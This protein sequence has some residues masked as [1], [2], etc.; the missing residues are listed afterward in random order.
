LKDKLIKKI[1][2]FLSRNYQKYRIYLYKSL[3]K[4]IFFGQPTI[5]QPTLFVGKGKI[6]FNGKI[7][8]GYF[9]S[10]FYFAGSS[11]IE[12]RNKESEII[13]G[14]NIY[15]NNNFTIIAE[16]KINFGNNILIGTNVEMYDSDFHPISI[17]RIGNRNYKTAPISIGNNV[18]I[19]SNVKILK[20]VFIGENS[21]IANGSIVTQDIPKNVVAAGIPAKIIKIIK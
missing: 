2:L 21:V 14:D 7:I 11:Y 13:F 12:A 15:I 4:N 5:L 9:P 3:S 8:L 20:G 19:G 6:K 18:W 16:T 1:I 10:P 17:E